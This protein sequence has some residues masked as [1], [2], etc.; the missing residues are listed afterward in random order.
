M[1]TQSQIGSN[2]GS[3]LGFYILCYTCILS[4]IDVQVY[5]PFY[6]TKVNGKLFFE[7]F[8]AL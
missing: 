4:Y 6:I 7:N 1:P 3:L 8:Y 2:E 5:N